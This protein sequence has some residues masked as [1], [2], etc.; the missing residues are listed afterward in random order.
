M[1]SEQVD[2]LY[3]LAGNETS[4]DTFPSDL[5]Q[6]LVSSDD[7]ADDITYVGSADESE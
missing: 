1:S 2:M 7:W 4:V 3:A 5:T 6:F